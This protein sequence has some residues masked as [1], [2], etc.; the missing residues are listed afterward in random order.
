MSAKKTGFFVLP[1]EFLFSPY[2]VYTRTLTWIMEELGINRML[3][4]SNP[5]INRNRMNEILSAIN[6]FVQENRGPK[7]FPEAGDLE[8][9]AEKLKYLIKFSY[10][11]SDPS[12]GAIESLTKAISFYSPEI[13]ICL[14][15]SEDFWPEKIKKHKLDVCRSIK[16][17]LLPW[18]EESLTKLLEGL[19]TKPE[20]VMLLVD[21]QSDLAIV[22][23][24]RITPIFFK[25]GIN[26]S[27]YD[28]YLPDYVQSLPS[29]A[30][31][32]VI[33]FYPENK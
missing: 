16:I 13:E 21:T 26:R 12:E 23:R 15:Y 29:I 10:T 20:N 32:E 1:I 19:G 14:V 3:E 6:E 28:H 9:I 31:L 33:R 5:R 27:H 24:A 4:F 7:I 8:T 18:T 17:N 22:E 25:G 30:L 11:F 2:L